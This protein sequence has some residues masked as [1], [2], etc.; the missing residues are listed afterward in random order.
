MTVVNVKDIQSVVAMIPHSQEELRGRVFV[1][2]KLT[3]DSTCIE[4]P[5]VDADIAT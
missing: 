4:D 1:V 2:E 3:L 5:T